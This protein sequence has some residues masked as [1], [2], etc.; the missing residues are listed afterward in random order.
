MAIVNTSIAPLLKEGSNVTL[1]QDGQVITIATTGGGGTPGGSDTQIQFNDG[2]AFG[3]DAGL[4]YD[5]TNNIVDLES[6]DFATTPTAAAATYR[7]NADD[8]EG[9]LN[10]GLKG[11]NVNIALGAEV[12]IMSYNAEATTLNKGEVV[13]LYGAQGQRPSVK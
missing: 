9:S 5:K 11:G 8:S 7:L 6:I 10:L 3:G 4:T 2:G 1:T 13:Y 12:V